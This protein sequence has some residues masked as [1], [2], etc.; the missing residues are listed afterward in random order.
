MKRLFALMAVFTL[1]LTTAAGCSKKDAPDGEVTP[2]ASV[3]EDATVTESPLS[4]ISFGGTYVKDNISLAF[5]ISNGSWNVTGFLPNPE[6]SLIL[7]GAIT[8]KELPTFTF[9]EDENTLTFTFDEKSVKVDV[10]SGTKYAGFAGNYTL[11]ENSILGIPDVSEPE[12][13]ASLE[14]L[15]RI[16]LAYYMI[17]EK[18]ATEFG[19]DLSASSFST[20]YMQDFLLA[21]TDLFYAAEADFDPELFDKSLC[22]GYSP[23]DLDALLRNASYG[24]FSL[25]DFIA[26]DNVVKMKNEKYY[27]PCHGTYAGGLTVTDKDVD[28]VVGTV[29]VT[30][31]A[32][33]KNSALSA[34]EMTLTTVASTDEKT[35]DILIQSMMFKT[36]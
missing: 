16:A 21:Y 34:V 6:G 28:A 36:K 9:T 17:T 24:K 14:Q 5:G 3:S 30:G 13:S 2:T 19:M 35:A 20:A 27:V 1:L 25:E 12:M 10:N 26:K 4:S 18:T 7:K 15:G 31:N 33:D 22:Y 11:D 32:A 8:I 29:T 23:E